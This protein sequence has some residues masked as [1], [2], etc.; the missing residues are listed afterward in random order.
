VTVALHLVLFAGLWRCLAEPTALLA[1]WLA[2]ARAARIR[3]A[4]EIGCQV[5]YYGGVAA[6]LAA[7]FL[8]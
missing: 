3:R 5:L 4:A 2:P 8:S 7:R 1:T 6:L